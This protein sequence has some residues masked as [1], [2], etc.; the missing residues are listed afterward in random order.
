MLSRCLI[1]LILL[2]EL[3]LAV[4]G[5]AK[6]GSEPPKECKIFKYEC[7]SHYVCVSKKQSDFNGV[8]VCD[9]F[10]G[11]RG[12]HCL[13]LTS[14]SYLVIVLFSI[15]F[16]LGIL[17]LIYNISLIHLLY[18]RNKLKANIWVTL[19][20][21]ALSTLIIDIAG[22]C[23]ALTVD[24]DK[25]MFYQEHMRQVFIACE[26][27]IFHIGSLAISLYWLQISEKVN[28]RK[29]DRLKTL[30]YKVFLYGTGLLWGGIALPYYLYFRSL[31]PVTFLGP[32]IVILA[33]YQGAKLVTGQLRNMENIEGISI[34]AC[35]NALELAN[36]IDKTSKFI[37]KWTFAFVFSTA[38]HWFTVMNTKPI[39]PNQ[40]SLPRWCQGQFALFMV[41][42]LSLSDMF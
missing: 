35:A 16:V 5:Y 40:N 31:G 9:R 3:S 18:K 21:N 28:G 11:F 12:E 2:F 36:G 10:F 23:T 24:V 15:I 30:K 42:P 25:Q 33:Y 26:L 27:F 37:I 4:N 39:Y 19:L 41:I 22:L 29:I 13:D 17:L 20:C 8:C 32:M 14:A 6:L 7:P 38:I 1:I 34:L